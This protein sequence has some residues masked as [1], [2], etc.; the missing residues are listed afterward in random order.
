MVLKKGALMRWIYCIRL[1]KMRDMGLKG[2]P[3]CVGPRTLWNDM[4]NATDHSQLCQ[5]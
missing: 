2:V 3:L 5:S 4:V 1:R